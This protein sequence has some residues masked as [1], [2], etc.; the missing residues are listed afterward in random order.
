VNKAGFGWADNSGY[1][2]IRTAFAHRRPAHRCNMPGQQ[3]SHTIRPSTS[4]QR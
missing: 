4:H 1:D 3:T 2:E